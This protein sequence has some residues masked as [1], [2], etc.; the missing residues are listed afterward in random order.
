[1]A[2]ELVMMAE[3]SAVAT[4]SALR[5][6]SSDNLLTS[7]ATAASRPVDPLPP[8]GRRAKPFEGFDDIACN[9]ITDKV[10]LEAS[11]QHGGHFCGV[12]QRPALTYW[13]SDGPHCD[14]RLATPAL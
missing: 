5:C 10:V 11:E 3:P 13:L 8:S 9:M 6:C 1:M 14:S 2:P 12:Q 7:S 4:V